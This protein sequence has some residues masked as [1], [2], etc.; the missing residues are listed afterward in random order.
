MPLNTF[1]KRHVFLQFREIALTHPAHRM[2]HAILIESYERCFRKICEGIGN[3]V[4]SSTAEQ[5]K[6][7]NNS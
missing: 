4:R 2:H 3:M 6:I 1:S 5:I 7:I